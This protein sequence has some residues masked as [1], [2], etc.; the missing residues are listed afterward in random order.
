[1]SSVSLLLAGL[2][3]GIGGQA[4]SENGGDTPR[5]DALLTLL[6]RADRRIADGRESPWLMRARC[7]R[8]G[9]A[10]DGCP[11]APLAWLG[12]GGVGTSGYWLRADPVHLHTDRHRLVML[13][14][15]SLG[16]TGIEAAALVAAFNAHFAASGWTLFAPHPRRWYL[17]LTDDPGIR[18]TPL[19]AALGQP[20]DG[21]LPEGGGGRYWRGVLNEAQMLLH[22]HAVN[23]VREAE[24]RPAINSLWLW[25]GGVL[26]AIT[27]GPWTHVYGNEPLALGLASASGMPATAGASMRDVLS[28]STSEAGAA[29]LVVLSD[30]EDAADYADK[31]AWA[32]ALLRLEQTWFAPLL[33]ALRR[34]ALSELRL[35]PGNHDVYVGSR[36]RLRRF[37]RRRRPLSAYQRPP[38]T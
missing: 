4:L 7:H 20:I 19:H 13:G 27:P 11:F 33:A 16:V 25:G 29:A 8:G 22:G 21:L 30:L 18:T 24:G 17:R 14:N 35:Y 10:A 34:G 9:D 31:P 23:A 26:P 32:D 28:A 37:W 5:A 2:F 38:A 1:M 6:A 3:E 12:E 15:R 36:A